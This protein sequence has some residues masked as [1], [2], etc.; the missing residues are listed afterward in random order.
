MRMTISTRPHTLLANA[1][2]QGRFGRR[3]A[4]AGAALAAAFGL[5]AGTAFADWTG[6]SDFD[7]GWAWTHDRTGAATLELT[8]D[9]SLWLGV[10]TA[11]AWD[12]TIAASGALRVVIDGSA[13]SH[14]H[15]VRFHRLASTGTLAAQTL[16][17]DPQITALA[18]A[19]AGARDTISVSFLDQSFIFPA[20]RAGQALNDYVLPC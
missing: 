5:A 2:R 18:Q 1:F 15:T 6:D 10:E 14:V 4:M 3:L 20:A 13:N 11:R 17:T 7:A 12:D 19:L 8:C 9:G 16:I